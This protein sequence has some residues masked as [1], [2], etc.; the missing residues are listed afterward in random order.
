MAAINSSILDAGTF[1]SRF[2]E[3]NGAAQWPRANVAT[4]LHQ[5][6]QGRYLPD[7]AWGEGLHDRLLD[8]AEVWQTNDVSFGVW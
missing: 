1:A 8:G 2:A 6:R 7:L 3:T 5:A 4:T